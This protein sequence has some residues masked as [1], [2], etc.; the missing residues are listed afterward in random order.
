VVG[1]AQ[2]HRE[3]LFKQ[4]HQFTTQV[5]TADVVG[6]GNAGP[7]AEIVDGLQQTFQESR[8]ANPVAGSDV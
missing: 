8:H 5:Y 6:R 1:Q 3:I 2:N 4:L 7:S